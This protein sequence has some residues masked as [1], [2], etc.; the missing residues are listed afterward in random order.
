MIRVTVT[1]QDLDNWIQ[2]PQNERELPVQAAL[3]RATGLNCYVCV[4][5]VTVIEEDEYRNEPTYTVRRLPHLAQVLNNRCLS[6]CR[7]PD[8]F[9]PVPYTFEV[10]LP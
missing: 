4:H 1:Q 6:Q 3:K 10:D 9:S 8:L 2:L 7:P 5:D